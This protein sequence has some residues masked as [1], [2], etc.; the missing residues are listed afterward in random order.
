MF[1]CFL[2]GFQYNPHLKTVEGEI[3]HAVGKAGGISENDR[4][5][6]AKVMLCTSESEFL[7]KTILPS[8]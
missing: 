3:A 7:F 2:Q 1:Y 6:L 5:C 8:I 4:G